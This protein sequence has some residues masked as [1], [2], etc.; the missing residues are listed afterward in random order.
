MGLKEQKEAANKEQLKALPDMLKDVDFKVKDQII[1]AD[2]KKVVKEKPAKFGG[3][4][5]I[6]YQI[7]E[8]PG[9]FPAGMVRITVPFF[10]IGGHTPTEEQLRSILAGEDVRVDD[11]VSK[12][13]KPYSRIFSFKSDVQTEYGKKGNYFGDLEARFPDKDE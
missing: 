1:K 13:G 10:G 2:F 5:S 8:V 11:N 7:E 4:Q 12:A 9:M 3:G 6:S